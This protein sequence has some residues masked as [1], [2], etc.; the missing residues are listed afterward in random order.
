[1][2]YYMEMYDIASDVK[3][4]PIPKLFNTLREPEIF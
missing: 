4:H 1:M 2:K 3:N